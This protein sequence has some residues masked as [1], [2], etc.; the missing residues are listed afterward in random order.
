M[1][2]TKTTFEECKKDQLLET[3]SGIIHIFEKHKDYLLAGILSSGRIVKL[4]SDGRVEYPQRG[5]KIR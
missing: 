5:D 3:S 2:K 1:G 4:W